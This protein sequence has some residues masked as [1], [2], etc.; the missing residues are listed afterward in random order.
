MRH[1]VWAL[2]GALWLAAGGV[3]EAQE[4]VRTERE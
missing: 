4:F 3:A 2:S 1:V